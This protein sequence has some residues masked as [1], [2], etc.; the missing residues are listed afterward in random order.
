MVERFFNFSEEDEFTDDPT[1]VT[2]EESDEENIAV[3]KIM[4]EWGIDE[5]IACDIVQSLNEE[6]LDMNMFITKN[7]DIESFKT[8]AE[9]KDGILNL[10]NTE[11][12]DSIAYVF[13]DGRPHNIEVYI[14]LTPKDEKS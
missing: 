5:E 9:L 12:Y 4:D 10:I 6:S 14:I 3:K 11:G 13:L 2:I 8:E 1:T 7:A